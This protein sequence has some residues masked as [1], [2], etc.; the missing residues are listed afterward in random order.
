MFSLTFTYTLFLFLNATLSRYPIIF[1]VEMNRESVARQDQFY[2][3]IQIQL[4][5]VVSGLNF[6][7]ESGINYDS[8]C[9]FS[10][11]FER[12]I[13]LKKELSKIPGQQ[14]T[15]SSHTL[16]VPPLIAFGTPNNSVK[17]SLSVSKARLIISKGRQ[18]K[19]IIKILN[20]LSYWQ[21]Q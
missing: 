13:P 11:Q 20:V 8:V 5:C 15:G 16:D 6:L 7:Y 14:L 18:G 21:R 3:P 12:F 2:T 10:N 4:E 9:P 19:K 1:Y 17:A